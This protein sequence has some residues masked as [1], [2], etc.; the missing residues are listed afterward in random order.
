MIVLIQLFLEFIYLMRSLRFRTK[1]LLP[2]AA[3]QTPLRNPHVM[4]PLLLSIP[5]IHKKIATLLTFP[6]QETLYLK[7]EV[8]VM[9][10]IGEFSKI[11]HLTLKTLRY[12]DEI[13]LLYLIVIRYR[14]P[15]YWLITIFK[16]YTNGLS[17]YN[18]R[19]I[20]YLKMNMSF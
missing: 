8:I 20:H 17:I 15:L 13:G 4:K 19:G 10:T 7:Q 11:S 2:R 16:K 6:L 18:I 1:H 12:Y 9:L 5:R 14:I 3:H